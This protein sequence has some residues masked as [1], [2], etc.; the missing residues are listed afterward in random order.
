M[1]CLRSTR[2]LRLR[3]TL[4][5]DDD[6]P[7]SVTLTIITVQNAVGATMS[8]KD[9]QKKKAARAELCSGKLPKFLEALEKILEQNGSTGKGSE[10]KPES[11]NI[12]LTWQGFML[13]TG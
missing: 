12:F 13:E 1:S 4:R 2:L 5:Y 10:R 9:C 6:E 11:S 3:L 8:I 7:E